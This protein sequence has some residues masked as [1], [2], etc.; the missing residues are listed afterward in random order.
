MMMDLGTRRPDATGDICD[1]AGAAQSGL[2]EQGSVDASVHREIAALI[3]ALRRYARALKRDVAAADDLVQECLCRALGKIHLWR[4]GS[5]L[6]AWLFTI[7]HNQHVNDVRR[8][9]R[10]GAHIAVEDV[11]STLTVAADAWSLMRMRDLQ[12]AIDNLPEARRLAVLLVGIEGM[13]YEDVAAILGVPVGTVRSR[14]F[15][16]RTRLREVIE[17]REAAPR[18]PMRPHAVANAVRVEM[19]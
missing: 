11:A 16:T 8:A 15:R 7:L 1:T 4:S 2:P 14:L 9:M 12:R 13:E 19:R 17:G 5:D 10:R 6:R 3:P 18:T